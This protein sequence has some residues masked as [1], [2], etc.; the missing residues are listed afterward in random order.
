MKLEY[1]LQKLEA[2]DQKIRLKAT[3]GPEEFAESLEMSKA[4]L[5]RYID[6]L[7]DYG[8]PIYYDVS[9]KS[10]CYEH[11]INIQF[12]FKV[13]PLNQYEAQKI[14]GGKALNWQSNKFS[15]IFYTSLKK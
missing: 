14:S 1:Y 5:Y 3:G 7:K 10:F 11:D 4:S 6:F 12:S 2:I 13:E 15:K 9:N 8:A